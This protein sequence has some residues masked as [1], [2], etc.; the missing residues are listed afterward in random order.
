MFI[1]KIKN[2][3]PQF[4]EVP[5]STTLIIAIIQTETKKKKGQSFIEHLYFWIQKDSNR[6][7]KNN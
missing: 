3:T 1:L 6:V 5:R 7:K 4:F 2:W